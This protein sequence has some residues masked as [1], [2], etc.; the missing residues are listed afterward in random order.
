MGE[1]QP[2]AEAILDDVTAALIGFKKLRTFKNKVVRQ[3]KMTTVLAEGFEEE[4]IP[5][6]VKGGC[7]GCGDDVK[8]IKWLGIEWVGVPKPVRWWRWAFS[9]GHPHPGTDVMWPGCGCIAYLYDLREF[10]RAWKKHRDWQA[11][12][13]RNK[14]T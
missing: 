5:R 1:G 3:Q 4:A 9:H 6:Q 2:P 8:R 11:T 10:W 7:P 12:R 14:I 13:Q